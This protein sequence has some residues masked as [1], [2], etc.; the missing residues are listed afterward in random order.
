MFIAQWQSIY[1]LSKRLW[2]RVLLNIGWRWYGIIK[3]VNLYKFMAELAYHPYH[4]VDVS[5]WPLVGACGAFFTTVG[6]VV[7]FH[8]SQG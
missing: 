8:Y 6:G 2:V 1:L 7:Y 3:V 4:L 5:P